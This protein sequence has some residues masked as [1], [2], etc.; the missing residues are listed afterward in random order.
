MLIRLIA[1][2]ICIQPLKRIDKLIFFFLMCVYVGGFLRILFLLPP[3]SPMPRAFS[4]FKDL[5]KTQRK[6]DI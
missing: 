5:E 6:M 2:F 4:D 1:N 3:T